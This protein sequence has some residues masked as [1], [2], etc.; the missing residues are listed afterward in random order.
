MTN[1]L[2]RRIEKGYL[3]E[4][5][6]MAFWFRGLNIHLVEVGLKFLSPKQWY[7]R[8]NQSLQ[9]GKR[10]IMMSIMIYNDDVMVGVG[11]TMVGPCQDVSS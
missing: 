3:S 8:V 1:L 7:S 5:L 4:N 9:M 11:G 6:W 10:V 2:L